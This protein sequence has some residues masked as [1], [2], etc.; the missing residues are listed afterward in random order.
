MELKYLNDN[1]YRDALEKSDTKKM[2][3]LVST[4]LT[5]FQINNQLM[6]S[7]LIDFQTFRF[8]Y[9]T[10]ESNELLSN[11]NDYLLK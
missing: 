11:F 6:T 8:I 5:K 3:L 10:L 7:G 9:E 2:N 4:A 1:E